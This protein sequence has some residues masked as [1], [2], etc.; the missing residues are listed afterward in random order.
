M[1]RRSLR[2]AWGGVAAAWSGVAA[3]WGDVAANG[4]AWGR[5]GEGVP[6]APWGLR[7]GGVR[8]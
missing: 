8:A 3:A 1:G 5:C 6:V 2:G 7:Q 4:V